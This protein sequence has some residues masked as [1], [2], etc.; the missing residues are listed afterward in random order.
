MEH[1]LNGDS[2][3]F[4]CVAGGV[5]VGCVAMLGYVHVR[6]KPAFCGGKGFAK[7]DGLT[8]KYW[9]GRGLM[10][11]PRLMLAKRNLY[12]S[13]GDFADIRVTTDSL[14]DYEA[15]NNTQLVSYDSVANTLDSNL[16]RMPILECN[17]KSIGQSAAINYFVAKRLDLLGDSD[18]EAG[19]VMS[20]LASLDELNA[21]MRKIIPYGVEPTEEQ[22]NQFFDEP[23]HDVTGPAQRS[24][25]DKRLFRW[26]CGRLENVIC[27]DSEW[28]VGK[29]MSLADISIYRMLYDNLEGNQA[30]D[31]LKAYRREPLGS[32]KK[33][34]E[35][36]RSYPKLLNIC[37]TV[38]SDP[39]IKKYIEERLLQRF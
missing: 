1:I 7:S 2:K 12:A 27:K 5:A 23:E 30:H 6:P 19:Q 15:G 18:L 16:G 3:V 21:S 25:R 9:N 14:D 37:K 11:V 29:R 32:M 26:Y 35:A 39:S 36:L 28:A 22:L 24:N 4:Y 31:N 34:N 17:G 10:E 8:L 20:V 13:A 38:K 33:V